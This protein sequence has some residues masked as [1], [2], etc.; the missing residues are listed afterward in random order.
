MNKDSVISE[1]LFNPDSSLK[2]PTRYKTVIAGRAQPLSGA[3]LIPP[4]LLL[5]AVLFSR[6]QFRKFTILFFEIFLNLM[7]GC[8]EELARTGRS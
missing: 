8:A 4:A 6:N 3:F 7:F 2:S 1:L 5:V